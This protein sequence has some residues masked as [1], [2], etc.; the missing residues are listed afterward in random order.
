MKKVP[1]VKLVPLIAILA[2]TT[3]ARCL[4]QTKDVLDARVLETLQQFNVIDPQ[5]AILETKAAGIL[6]FPQVSKGGIALA[7]G[8]GEGVLEIPGKPLEYYSIASASVGLTA[9]VGAYSEVIMFMTAE[10]LDQFRHSKGWSLSA[11]SGIAVMSTGA[12]KAYEGGA[13]RKP[14]LVFVFGE[15]GLIADLSLQGSKINKIVK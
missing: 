7:S 13:T 1:P 6:I 15:K 3:N 12:A 8:Y 9:G 4:A 2:L 11:D 14:V 10:A 5:H